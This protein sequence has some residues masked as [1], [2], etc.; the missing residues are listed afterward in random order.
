MGLVSPIPAPAVA[1]GYV[2]GK[3]PNTQGR[4]RRTEPA[5]R[6][7]VDTIRFGSWAE[8]QAYGH[9]A[10]ARLAPRHA[11]TAARCAPYGHARVQDR[12][13]V[14]VHLAGC[15]GDINA[16]ASGLDRIFRELPFLGAASHFGT[17][18]R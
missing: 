5:L 4:V 2:Q 7:G 1:G 16:T 15:V 12:S 14:A 13:R 18:T 8:P 10:A 17:M 11:S 9:C 3:H 6:P